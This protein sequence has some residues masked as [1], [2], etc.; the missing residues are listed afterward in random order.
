MKLDKNYYKILDIEIP[1]TISYA[2]EADEDEMEEDLSRADSNS[3]KSRRREHK[4]IMG[5]ENGQHRSM[6]FPDRAGEVGDHQIIEESE[7]LLQSVSSVSNESKLEKDRFMEM[8]R[9]DK[10]E[11]ALSNETNESDFKVEKEETK[12]FSPL[13]PFSDA[14]ANAKYKESIKEDKV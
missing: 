13:S 7:E 14:S 10:K 3:S 2:S 1:E 12:L 6:K 4:K 8:V 9:G 11:K 5:Q